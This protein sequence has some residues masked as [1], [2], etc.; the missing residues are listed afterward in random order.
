[1]LRRL[2][3]SVTMS[4]ASTK[5]NLGLQWTPATSTS[6]MSNNSTL[7]LMHTAGHSSPEFK[8]ILYSVSDRVAHIQ[9]NRP[10]VFNAID[11]HIPLEVE[12]AVAMANAD[13]AVKVIVLSGN[14]GVFCSGYDLKKFAESDR[15]EFV[16]NQKMP[17]DPYIDYRLMNKCNDHWMSIWKS[18]KPVIAKIEC[19]AIGGGSDIA[20]CC[21]I[22]VIAEDAK[23]GYPPSRVFGCPTTAMWVYRV[24]MERAKRILLSGQILSGKE[25]AEIGLIGEAVPAD[26]LDDAVNRIVKRLVTVPTNQLFF[27]KQVINQAIEQMGLFSSQ[28]LSVL[29]DGMSRH[30]PEGILFQKRANEV[31][32]KQAVKERDSGEEAVWSNVTENTKSKL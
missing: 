17:W 32:F 7:K 11:E 1:M 28:R 13:D 29:F 24:G 26:Q 18:L 22:T 27:Q 8:S 14:G 25:A 5:R 16:G 20:L 4:K 2:A 23:I 21:D 3:V 12:Q 19:V 15:G 30:S 31:G 10:H 6:G 9:L